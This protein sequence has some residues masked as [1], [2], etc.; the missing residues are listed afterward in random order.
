[1]LECQECRVCLELPKFGH[2]YQ[3]DHKANIINHLMGD[4]NL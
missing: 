1:M 4:F 3:S 2:K